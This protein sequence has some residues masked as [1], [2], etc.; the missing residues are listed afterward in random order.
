MR[1]LAVVAFASASIA[2][3][4]YSGPE[5]VE[6][7]AVGDRYFVSNT[8]SSVIKVRSQAG[9]VADW[10]SVN[11]APYGLEIMGDILF[12]CS[13][14]TIK[15]YS[16]NDASL[17]FNLNLGA[18]FLNGL[19]TDGEFLYATDFN[20][21]QRK[22]HKVDPVAGTSQVLVANTGGQPNGIVW[23]PVG[24]RLV[25]VFWGSSAP[26][27]AYDRETGA[28]TVL[29][30]NSGLAN[31]D[32]IT[33]D[34]MGAFLVSS[35]TPARLTRFMPDFASAGVNLGITG[36][37]SPADLDFDAVN[38][39]VCIPNSGSNTVT[40]APLDCTTGVRAA[41]APLALRAVPNPTNGLLRIEPALQ[42]DEPYM[43]FDAR[44][45]LVGGGMARNG[46]LLDI[47]RLSRGT[48]FIEFN[49]LGQRLRV[50]KE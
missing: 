37:S 6:Y 24:E 45:L 48:Y 50:V 23:D 36:L 7:D 18:T 41:A 35:W 11:P 15:G 10:V 14:G 12:A 39:R 21:S 34:C 27:K 29:T 13:G 19:A 47:T 1:H 46:A 22:I 33:I 3:A 5:S 32:G 43:L 20:T 38:N 42:R 25:V 9:T 31:L 30:S 40:L 28:E 2:Q 8:N 44:G 49:R 16:L 17:V 26:I 4:Q